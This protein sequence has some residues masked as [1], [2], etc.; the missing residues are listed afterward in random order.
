ME[1]ITYIYPEDLQNLQK[2]INGNY[3]VPEGFVIYRTETK[4]EKIEKLIDQINQIIIENGDQPSD[5]EL[6]QM[7]KSL[8]PYY[9]GLNRINQ[10]NQELDEL[11]NS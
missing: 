10:L 7:G 6:I 5:D 11:T 2:D 8:H 9:L 4:P 3:I 1:K